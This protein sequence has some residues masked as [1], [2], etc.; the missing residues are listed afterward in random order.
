[1]KL[2][3]LVVE[4]NFELPNILA[5]EARWLAEQ[6]RS[7]TPANRAKTR[8]GIY[9]TA[10]GNRAT[11][12]IRFAKQYA[13]QHPTHR[14]LRAQWQELRPLVR[15]RIIEKINEVLQGE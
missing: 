8:S 14:R 7:Q 3:D 6:I 2:E 13:G 9:W 10:S 15:Q 1:M 11:V 5:E 12:G 4:V